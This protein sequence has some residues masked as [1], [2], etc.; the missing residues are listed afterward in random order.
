MSLLGTQISLL[1]RI[2][3]EDSIRQFLH[4]F[5]TA[6]VLLQ[7]LPISFLISITSFF[8]STSEITVPPAMVSIAFSLCDT[9]LN[10]FEVGQHTT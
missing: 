10:G 2:Y 3:D 6:K 4:F 5:D 8:G 7:L 9:A 1:L